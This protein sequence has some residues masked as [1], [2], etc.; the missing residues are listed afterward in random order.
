M[1]TIFNDDFRDFIQAM[2]K[3]NVEYILVGGYAVILHGYRRVTG[4]MDIWVNRTK[5]NYLKL[6][7]AFMEFGL[8]IY[9]MTE[10]K[11][12]ADNIDVFSY[13]RPPVSIDI[14]TNLKGVE[15]NSAFANAQLFNDEG[16]MIRFLHLNNLIE[17]KKAVGRHKDL[18]DIEKLTS[19]NDE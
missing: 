17:A 19:G 11:F 16:L 6:T 15:F 4:D 18:D 1:G 12:F 14:I 2:N 8:P 13:G 7:L 9:D 5:E 3:H 10:A